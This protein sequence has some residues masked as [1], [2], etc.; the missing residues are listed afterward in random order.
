M[1]GDA[2]GLVQRIGKGGQALVFDTL[3]GH[4]RYRVR[5]LANRLRHLA[6]DRGRTGDV[7]TGVFGLIAQGDGVHRGGAEVDGIAGGTVAATRKRHHVVVDAV[8][9]VGALKHPCQRFTGLVSALDRQRLEVGYHF[10]AIEE[11]QVG[12]FADFLQGAGQWLGRNVDRHG[13]RLSLG[14]ATDNQCGAQ[15]QQGLVAALG[16]R[17]ELTVQRCVAHAYCPLSVEFFV[18]ANESLY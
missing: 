6:A 5:H 13:C 4:H 18:I 8:G 1:Q 15:C 2:G 16:V 14:S 10:R 11:L 3:T 12:L 7:G 9:D 17:R